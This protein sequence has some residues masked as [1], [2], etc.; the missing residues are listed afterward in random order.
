MYIQSSTVLGAGVCRVGCEAVM[1]KSDEE[2]ARSRALLKLAQIYPLTSKNAVMCSVV[3]CCVVLCWIASCR[4]LIQGF[5]FWFLIV[6]DC[7]YMN[8]YPPCLN[9]ISLCIFFRSPLLYPL[10]L[11]LPLAPPLITAGGKVVFSHV[12]PPTLGGHR[13]AGTPAK[14]CSLGLTATSDIPV[15]P[16]KYPVSSDISLW[17]ASQHTP[18]HMHIHIHTYTH[19]LSYSHIHT[20]T[21]AGFVPLRPRH[22]D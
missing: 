4:N 2:N 21:H 9:N 17:A 13:I 1:R 7:R 18:I 11:S 19:S 15:S 3:W 6:N 22:S 5:T 12:L 8:H 14:Y 20:H 10:I 16:V